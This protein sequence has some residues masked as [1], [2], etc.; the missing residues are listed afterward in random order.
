MWQAVVAADIT[1]IRAPMFVIVPDI[2][3]TLRHGPC[4]WQVRFESERTDVSEGAES[5]HLIT[6]SKFI[7]PKKGDL[8]LLC[9]DN[10]LELWVP[11]YW[12]HI[13]PWQP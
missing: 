9:F 6:Q 2:D 1:N 5:S 12:P 3:P 4:R 8:C 13:Y 11:L 10:R 7:Y